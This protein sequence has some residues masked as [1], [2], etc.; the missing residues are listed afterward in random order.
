[1]RYKMSNDNS[2]SSDEKDK[3]SRVFAAV[4]AASIQDDALKTTSKG[5]GPNS[6]QIANVRSMPNN[7]K[8]PFPDLFGIR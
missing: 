8:S 4:T 1:M 5:P 6:A 7:G 2:R 3:K